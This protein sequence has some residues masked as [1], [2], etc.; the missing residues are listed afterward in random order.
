MC[1]GTR[2]LPRLK[3]RFWKAPGRLFWRLKIT[4]GEYR[5]NCWLTFTLPE[6]EWAWDLLASANGRGSWAEGLRLNRVATVQWF[7]LPYLLGLQ[8]KNEL[9]VFSV[10]RF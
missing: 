5:K 4:G 1:I 8:A 3:S 7:E 6:P 9:A 2:A 10:P